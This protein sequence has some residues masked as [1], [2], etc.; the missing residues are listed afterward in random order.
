MGGMTE[1][2]PPLNDDD[3]AA[4]ADTDD[5]GMVRNLTAEEYAASYGQGEPHALPDDV[6]AALPT[7][8]APR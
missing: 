5:G 2:T 4:T 6:L 1:P 3:P 7:G 8:E